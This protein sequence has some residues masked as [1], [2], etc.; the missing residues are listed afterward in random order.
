M[1]CVDAYGKRQSIDDDYYKKAESL[2][3]SSFG[4]SNSALDYGNK[5]LN[6]S[7]KTMNSIFSKKCIEKSEYESLKKQF[8]KQYKLS[9]DEYMLVVAAGLLASLVQIFMVGIPQR[10][11]NGTKAGPLSN[12][13]RDYFE[14]KYSTEE[15]RKLE[16]SA[17]SK[18]P[19]DAQTNVYAGQNIT[20]TYVDGLNPY[21]HRLVSLGHDPI[22]GFVVGIFDIMNGS[23][24]T[25]DRTGR[26]V[27]QKI[28]KYANRRESDI[29]AAIAK[30]IAHLK[31]DVTTSMG[32]PAPFMGVANILQFGN[33]G[34]NGDTIAQIVQGMYYEGYDFIH[35]V[36][37]TIPTMIVEVFVRL[38]MVCKRLKNG[39]GIKTAVCIK[40]DE[41]EYQKMQTILFLS[42]AIV[43]SINVG[44][45][46]FTKNPMVI[47]YNEW[48][49]FS[50]Y[51]IH[52]ML[53]QFV[54]KPELR[55]KYILQNANIVEIGIL[56]YWSVTN[57]KEKYIVLE[58]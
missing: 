28:E 40:K 43:T 39:M 33:F 24:T 17:L 51:A 16:H 49:S 38:Y 58:G 20:S 15:I 36:S 14:K 42:H 3:Q 45:L 53:W 54:K 57:P 35:F 34:E 44:Q 37:T 5:L 56:D 11:S 26:I 7:N 2:L 13:I 4:K 1:Y 8:E 50:K 32:L 23:M 10:T 27:V 18:V 19:F 29:F 46:L 48:I 55:E 52:Q 41:I 21:Y 31:T 12:Y 9:N 25:I 22:L 47:N 30:E 6:Q